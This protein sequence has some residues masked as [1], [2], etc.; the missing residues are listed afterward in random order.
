LL[1]LPKTVDLFSGFPFSEGLLSLDVLG[2]PGPISA[3][4]L[5]LPE[6]VQELEPV[7]VVVLVGFLPTFS[8]Y[9]PLMPSK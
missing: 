5:H 4:V 2:S 8:S 3:I 9:A 7:E 6:V 1:P